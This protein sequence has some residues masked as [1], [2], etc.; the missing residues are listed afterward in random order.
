MNCKPSTLC[1]FDDQDV[2]TDIISNV[3]TDYHPTTS[4]SSGGAIEFF[5]PGSVDEYIDFS[6]LNLQIQAKILKPDGK[7]IGSYGRRY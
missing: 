6:D 4:I 7:A 5:I 3:I 2:Q 1:V